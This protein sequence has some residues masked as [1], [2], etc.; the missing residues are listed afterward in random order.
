MVAI[1]AQQSYILNLTSAITIEDTTARSDGPRWAPI[2]T[3]T[4]AGVEGVGS[5]VI[6]AEFGG[7]GSVDSVGTGATL[8]TPGPVEAP[9][10]PV[11]PGR[12]PVTGWSGAPGCG[13]CGVTTVAVWMVHVD[14]EEVPCGAGRV[15]VKTG[16]GVGPVVSGSGAIGGM[17]DTPTG[18][19]DGG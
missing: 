18:A 5:G 3:G 10:N 12:L 1:P 7:L 19:E 17:L 9:G 8:L 4:V 11:S 13:S 6:V 2:L 14:P 16:L 15:M